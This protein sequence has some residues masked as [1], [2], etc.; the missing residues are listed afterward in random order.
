[1][2]TFQP[3]DKPIIKASPYFVGLGVLSTDKYVGGFENGMP[4]QYYVNTANFYRQIRNLVIDIQDAD[5][6][7]Y[8]AAL[9]YQVAQAT[10]LFNVDFVCSRQP[11]TTQQAIC[12]C[13]PL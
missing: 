5:Q 8:V 13:H 6:N 10:S 12:K 4:K 9:H 7:A 11:G 1:M 3:N 2:R